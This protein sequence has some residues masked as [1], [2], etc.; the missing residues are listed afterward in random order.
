MAKHN[1]RPT[2]DWKSL[3]INSIADLIVGII[4]M[5]LDKAL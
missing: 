1:K 4:L 2:I 5:I 3:I